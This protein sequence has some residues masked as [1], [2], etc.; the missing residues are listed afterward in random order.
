MSTAR[1]GILSSWDSSGSYRLMANSFFASGR[2]MFRQARKS[3]RDEGMVCLVGVLTEKPCRAGKVLN[4]RKTHCC[5]M[6]FIPILGKCKKLVKVCMEFLINRWRDDCVDI[7]PEYNSLPL[8]FV[9]KLAS[10][11]F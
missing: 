9:I 5:L 7:I 2:Y 3:I 1:L 4:W 11:N 6:V 10:W 8:P